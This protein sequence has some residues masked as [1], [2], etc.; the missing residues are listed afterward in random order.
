MKGNIIYKKT[1]P[2]RSPEYAEFP[3]SLHPDI[4]DFLSG[5]NIK[6]LYTHQA[7][8]F[9]H[10]MAGENIVITTPTASGKSL[11]FYLPVVQEIL[12]DPVTRAIFIYPTKALAADQYRALIP[13][14]EALGEHRLSVGVYDGDTPPAER[15]RIR[16]R[17]NIILTNPDMLNG[18]M[19]PNHSKYGFDFIFSNLKYIILDELHVYRG[20]FG[21]HLANVFRRLSRICRYYHSDPQFLCS[22][23]TIANP[24]E[25]A[26]KICGRSF[27]NIARSGAGISERIYCLVQPEDKLNKDGIP[28]GKESVIN[29]AADL[30]PQLMERRESFLAFARS[31]KN[32][33]I[34]VKETRDHLDAAGFLGTAR[35]EEISG[36]RG[37]Y[38]PLERKSIEQRMISG[39]FLALYPPMH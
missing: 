39:I 14:M 15:K 25:L 34:L 6:S 38:T 12:K 33:E 24:L 26:E 22:S 2:A 16:E 37:G 9:S 36:Y 35:K 32:V 17:A 7:E 29:V 11:C 27:I 21:S 10:A 19:L 1:I 28:Y 8:A 30:L 20:A 13:W 18:S 23:A 3:K 5:Q 4:Q 31:R